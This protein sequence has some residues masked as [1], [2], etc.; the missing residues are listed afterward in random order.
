MINNNNNNNNKKHYDSSGHL[1]SSFNHVS[2]YFF[3]KKR[4]IKAKLQNKNPFRTIR[5]FF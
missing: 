5:V 2:I 1:T 3:L 4:K